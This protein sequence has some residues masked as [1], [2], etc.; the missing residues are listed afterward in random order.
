MSDPGREG[1]IGSWKTPLLAAAAAA[2]L[3]FVVVGVRA[4]AY[5]EHPVWDE[6]LLWSVARE[7]YT[8]A[9]GDYTQNRPLN[10]VVYPPAWPLL[11]RGAAGI[12]GGWPG[13]RLILAAALLPCSL[14]LLS[15]LLSR[16]EPDP[17]I[18][19]R[20]L[21][22]FAFGPGAMYFLTGYSE[23]LY[24]LCTVAFFRALLDRRHGSAAVAG[25]A[26]IL[27]KSSGWAFALTHLAA[28]LVELS[29]RKESRGAWRA[30]GRRLLGV[31][32]IYA[33]APAIYMG[34]L[35]HD[36]GDPWAWTKGYAAW[37][38]VVLPGL[39]PWIVPEHFGRAVVRASEL[40]TLWVALVWF[41]AIPPVMALGRRRLPFVIVAACAIY[42]GML[43]LRDTPELPLVDAMRWTS[44]LFPVHLVL[45]RGLARAG[46]AGGT[47]GYAV[48]LAGGVVLNA[49]CIDAFAHGRWVS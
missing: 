3:F 11:L 31:A 34:L 9:G 49:W 6:S 44:V 22:L 39:E 16:L 1:A 8:L 25:A 38:R 18:V 12:A 14:W 5:V 42:W 30:L 33:A 2:A 17:R 21:W 7:G 45:V 26:A 37:I 46:R 15:G 24:L 20:S 40:P 13:V 29:G 48:T 35:A 41:L 19:R 32:P 28:L 27:T 4:P 47:I 43:L 36:V 23:P 10:T